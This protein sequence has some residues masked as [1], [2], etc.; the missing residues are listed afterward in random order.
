MAAPNNSAASR[1]V[2]LARSAC[3]ACFCIALSNANSASL[4]RR[5]ADSIAS[6]FLLALRMATSLCRSRNSSARLNLFSST[7]ANNFC[8]SVHCCSRSCSCCRSSSCARAIAAE[9]LACTGAD[10]GLGAAVAAAPLGGQASP[11]A[12]G[13]T[14]ASSSS[15]GSA[16]VLGHGPCCCCCC[17][18]CI[19]SDATHSACC[20]DTMF[21]SDSHRTW[22]S[23]CRA[24]RTSAAVISSPL[25]IRSAT[26]MSSAASTP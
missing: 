20:R 16:A 19:S 17:C 23:N 3:I 14:A 22:P 15:P 24:Y 11:P 18:S 21:N 25:A 6:L 2:D 10:C 4:S 1:T 8:F 13:A 26:K 12:S 7:V 9:S 5:R